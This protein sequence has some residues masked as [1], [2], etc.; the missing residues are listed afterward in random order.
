MSSTPSFS[1]DA[2]DSSR[3]TSEPSVLKDGDGIVARNI[4]EE[5]DLDRIKTCTEELQYL[6]DPAGPRPPLP[7]VKTKR[8][9]RSKLRSFFFGERSEDSEVCQIT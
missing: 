2:K 5:E 9:P 3:S 6:S 8:D 4:A 1:D 7:T